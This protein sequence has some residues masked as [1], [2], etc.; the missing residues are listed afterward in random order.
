[1]PAVVDDPG[2][3][4]QLLMMGTTRPAQRGARDL[5]DASTLTHNQLSTSTLA[6][7]RLV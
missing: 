7:H 5:D 1:M 2:F 3:F 4:D 6:S